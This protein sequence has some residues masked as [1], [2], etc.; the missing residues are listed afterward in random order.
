MPVSFAG[1][2]SEL[3]AGARYDYAFA[4]D[5]VKIAVGMIAEEAQVIPEPGTIALLAAA[6]LTFLFYVCRKRFSNRSVQSVS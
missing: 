3:P 2:A 1:G 6:G 5:V 4:T